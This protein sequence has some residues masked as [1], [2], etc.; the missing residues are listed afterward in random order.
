[1]NLQVKILLGEAGK[2]APEDQID[3]AESIL[4]NLPADAEWDHAWAIEGQ[5]RLQ[6]VRRGE[7]ATFEADEVFA[8]IRGRL[9]NA[10]DRQ[11]P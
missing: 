2:L 3:L 11:R 7:D 4:V 5:R 10:K 6:A 9:A 1:M 8:D